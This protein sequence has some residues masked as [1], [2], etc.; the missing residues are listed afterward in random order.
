MKKR[1]NSHGYTEGKKDFALENGIISWGYGTME[2]DPGTAEKTSPQYDVGEELLSCFSMS[3]VRARG[4][5]PK[6]E[7]V[8]RER[9]SEGFH[10]N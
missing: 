6:G 2:K 9:E 3:A 1:Q 8:V 7:K 10:K 4:Y 5:Q